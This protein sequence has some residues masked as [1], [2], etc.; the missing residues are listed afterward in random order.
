MQFDKSELSSDA[1]A[2]AMKQGH[3]RILVVVN[4]VEGAIELFGQVKGL[5]EKQGCDCNLL[6]ARFLPEDRKAK[7]EWVVQRFGKNPSSSK[8]LPVPTQVVEAGWDISADCLLSEI[9][10]EEE[11]QGGE[12]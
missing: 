5:A 2:R 11:Q 3:Q 8:S 4:T 9:A 1:V 6:H 7:E 12:E 10:P